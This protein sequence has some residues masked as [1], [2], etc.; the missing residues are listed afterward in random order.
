MKINKLYTGIVL[1]GALM[2]SGCGSDDDGEYVGGG[3]GNGGPI[4]N[5]ELNYATFDPFSD[6]VNGQYK[7]GWGKFASTLSNKG[8]TQIISTLVGSSPTA[9][10]DSRSDNLGLEYYVGN[11]LF[12]AVPEEFDSKF[13]KINFVD[14]DTFK[15][16]IQSGSSIVNSTYD[17][18]TL[19]LTGVGK[20]PG[21]AQTGIETDLDYFP[22]SFNATFPSGSQCYIFLETPD[23]D[24]YTFSDYDEEGSMT[25]D[26]WIAKEKKYNTVSNL[27]KENV[28]SKNELQAVRYTDEDG[29][30]NAAVVYK[31]LIYEAYYYQKGIQEKEDIDPNIAEVYCNQY[32]SVATKF[33][34]TQI[35]AVYQN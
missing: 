23:Q 1:A 32:N 29:D 4:V 31:G 22:D 25:I 6:V 16:K 13:Y 34:E 2:V 20:Q 30:I 17:I 5:N 28:G 3:S 21:N 18:I 8:L 26:Q 11:N 19:D 35:K 7:T 33:L 27:V 15:L 10:Q 14:S 24:Y 9:Y 12:A